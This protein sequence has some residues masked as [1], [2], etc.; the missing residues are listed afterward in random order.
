MAR[1]ISPKT[2]VSNI[3][4]TNIWTANQR[5]NDCVKLILGT[6]ADASIFYNQTNLVIKPN[7][8]GCGVLLLQGDATFCGQQFLTLGVFTTAQRGCAGTAGRIIWNTCT[9]T[10]NVDDGICWDSIG[11]GGGCGDVSGPACAVDNAIARFNGTT[12]KIIQGYTSSPPL[13]TD[14]GAICLAEGQLIFPATQNASSNANTFDDYEKGEF[15]PALAD[16]SLDG[17]CENQVYTAQI[18]HYT[19][20]G[21]RL[22]WALALTTSSIGCLIGTNLARIVGFPFS[23]VNTAG[24]NHPGLAGIGTGLAIT[25]T[26]HLVG[27]VGSNLA[28]MELYEWDATT[29]TSP[30]TIDMWSANGLI[31]MQGVYEV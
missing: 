30:L 5:Y 4:Q 15:T 31:K 8:V 10:L 14:L 2:F 12:G 16:N 18:G 13:I 27:N 29:G 3:G 9:G 25:A 11:V 20:I 28:L 17:A 23:A 1:R 21:N 24:L 19:K 7:D 22:F 6:G 26:G